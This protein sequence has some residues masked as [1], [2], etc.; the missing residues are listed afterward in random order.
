MCPGS[1]GINAQAPTKT[2]SEICDRGSHSAI[3]ELSQLGSRFRV[4]CLFGRAG[5][6]AKV[7]LQT[8]EQCHCSQ[9]FVLAKLGKRQLGGQECIHVR[10]CTRCRSRADRASSSPRWLPDY[11]LPRKL[12][13]SRLHSLC[14][15]LP[16][17]RLD[18]GTFFG[19]G[20]R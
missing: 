19:R 17:A 14:A 20:L 16:T 3:T 12:R 8:W 11:F 10:P 1:V 5:R 9:S 15:R 7:R 13:P 6:L 2:T 4:G 18:R